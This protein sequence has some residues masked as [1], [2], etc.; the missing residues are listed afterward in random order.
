MSSWRLETVFWCRLYRRLTHCRGLYRCQ[1]RQATLQT[2]EIKLTGLLA[3]WR[4]D[5]RRCLCLVSPSVASAQSVWFR[6]GRLL[7]QRGARQSGRRVKLP[8]AF[9]HVHRRLPDEPTDAEPS[10]VIYSLFCCEFGQSAEFLNLPPSCRSQSSFR[11]LRR[12]QEQ[13]SCAD[14]AHLEVFLS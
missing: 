4:L 5:L 12:V 1:Q 14:T 6:R 7:L 11:E 9:V 13:Q 3:L 2:P 10:V 8:A